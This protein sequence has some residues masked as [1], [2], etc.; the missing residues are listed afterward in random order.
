[1]STYAE[2]TSVPVERSRA[3]IERTLERY[4]ADQFL[5][6]WDAEAAIV[7]FRAHG[8]HVAFWLPLPRRDDPKFT[9]YRRARYGSSG[10]RSEAE[11]LKRWEQACR[12]RWRA[13]VLVIKAKLEAVQTGITDFES[14][15]MAHIVLPNGQTV[16]ALL[17][18]QVE[19]AYSSGQMPTGLLPALESGANGARPTTRRTR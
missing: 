3:E 19:Q 1:M 7:R 2:Q 17:K 10:Q 11:A 16:G 8:R 14:E 15:F 13:L 6:G 9:E 12:Q 18:P 5:Y 4:G